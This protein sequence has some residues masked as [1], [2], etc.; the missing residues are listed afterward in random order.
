MKFSTR[1]FGGQRY[2]VSFLG[3]GERFLSPERRLDAMIVNSPD[4][5]S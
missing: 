3:G 1:E 4:L 2:P 5:F